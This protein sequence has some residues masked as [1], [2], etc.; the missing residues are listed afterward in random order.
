MN[1][2]KVNEIENQNKET[3]IPENEEIPV[4]KHKADNEVETATEERPKSQE[5]EIKE[6]VSL[7]DQINELKDQLLRKAAEFENYKRRTE[8]YQ[9][10][11]LKYAAE[12]FILK[13]LPVYN[14]FERSLSH[15]KEAKDVDAIKAGLQ[16]VFDKFTKALNEQGVSRM[17]TVGK[18]FDFNLH[19]ALLQQE[20]EDAPPN[21]VI[22]E[23]EPGYLYKDKVLKH[24]KVIVSK[25]KEETDSNEESEN[26]ETK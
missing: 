11:L 1:S 18:E 4:E 9:S 25:E 17:E 16:L 20:V 7:E 13:V 3:G 8:V 23:V 6:E 2:K 22:Q 5:E 19:E 12:S 10:E 24:A 14:D 26:S 21:T 15:I